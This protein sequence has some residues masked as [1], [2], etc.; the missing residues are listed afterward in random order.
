MLTLDQAVFCIVKGLDPSDATRSDAAGEA[1]LPVQTAGFRV[2]S[3]LKICGLR[4]ASLGL[5][6]SGKQRYWG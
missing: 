6:F 4:S 5:R 2:P 1:E 3:R